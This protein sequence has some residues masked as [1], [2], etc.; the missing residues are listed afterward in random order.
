MNKLLLTIFTVL[1][2][3]VFTFSVFAQSNAQLEKELVSAI[4]E[5]QKYSN[6]GENSD[7]EKLSKANDT[8]EAKLLKYTKAASTLQCKF[9]EL[10]EILIIATSD[11]GKFR[12]YSWDMEDGGTMHDYRSVYQYVGADSKIYSQTDKKLSA[13]DGGVGSF[14]YD[15]FAVPNKGGN[16]YIAC[17][18]F[19]GSTSDHYQSAGLYKITGKKLNGNVKLIK[20]KSGLTDSIGFEYNFFSV[21]DREERPIKLIKYNAKTK[22]LKIPVVI[23]KDENDFGTVTDKF[24]NYRFNGTYF[25]KVN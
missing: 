2:S 15:I 22:T 23:K 21:V 11:D 18:T 24:I 1:I 9:S 19:I 4:K 14:V 16:I 8:F 20:T 3:F 5:V 12:I 13:E 10:G 6:Y 25:V 17:S 7:D